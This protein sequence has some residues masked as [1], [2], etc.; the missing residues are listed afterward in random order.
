MQNDPRTIDKIFNG[1]NKTFDDKNMWLAPFVRNNDKE[2]L[3][4][5]MKNNTI[6]LSFDKIMVI[7]CINL[8]NYAKTPSRGV[9]ELEIF[10]DENLIFKVFLLFSSKII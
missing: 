1:I 9:N 3:A 8:Y 4:N 6:Y 5:G 10:L 7:S 2:N